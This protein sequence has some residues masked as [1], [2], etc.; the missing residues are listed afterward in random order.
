MIGNDKLQRLIR[1]GRLA[2][3]LA[4]LFTLT[5]CWD[6][7]E[8]NDLAIVLATGVDAFPNGT[9]ELS[10]QIFIPRAAGGGPQGNTG[11][12]GGNSTGDTLVRKA[13]GRTIAE[14]M[15]R[16][17]RRTSRHL[18]WGHSEVIVFGQ[19][20]AKGGIRSYLDFFLRYLQFREHAYV[21][22]AKG[23]ASSA[24][25][26]QPLLERSSSEELREMGN[27]KLG[28]LVTLKKLTQMVEGDSQSAV[29]TVIEQVSQKQKN[30]TRQMTT[31]MKGLAI[32]RKDKL[33]AIIQEPVTRGLLLIR[34]ELETMT[35][36][37]S[38]AGL[39]GT[40]SVNLLRARA[41][42]SP[43]IAANGDWKLNLDV[44][45]TGDLILNT[46]DMDNI[47][48]T[49]MSKARTAWAELL[50]EDVESALERIQSKLKVDAFG[51][52]NHFR[53]RY[54]RQWAREKRDWPIL[55]DK[56]KVNVVIQTKIARIGKSDLPQ[57]IP[58]D[59]IRKK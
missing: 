53:R 44:R 4:L 14:A 49:F 5:G 57:G 18:F 17:Q 56:I 10:A 32:L 51:F 19:E 16:L 11:G 38:L 25:D 54:P 29:L 9:V 15:T 24:L 45:T 36:S 41:H 21:Y 13:Q 3:A 30:G 34:N 22:V 33:V 26:N 1:G 59:E 7:K 35:Y 37:F 52:A 47:A 8:I 28:M 6:R 23:M 39:D 2:T 12:S 55:F 48:E 58:E 46:T 20:A 42:L 50:R 31:S 27:L 43:V 40:A